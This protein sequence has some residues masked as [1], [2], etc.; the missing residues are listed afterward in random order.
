MLG[1]KLGKELGLSLGKELGTPLSE[2]ALDG[3]KLW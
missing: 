3:T 2:G 1:F